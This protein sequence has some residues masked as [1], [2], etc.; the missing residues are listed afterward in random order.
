MEITNR[1]QLILGKFSKNDLDSNFSDSYEKIDKLLASVYDHEYSKKG[2]YSDDLDDSSYGTNSSGLTLIKNIK[3]VEN[4]FDLETIDKIS[5]DA[6]D[7]YG[8]YEI[9]GNEEYLAK[10]TKDIDLLKNLLL[11]KD[12]T[13][14]ESKIRIKKTILEIAKKLK[15]EL[16]NNPDIVPIGTKRNFCSSEFNKSKH[17]DIHKTISKNIKNY[18]KNK[19]K[20]Y[21]ENTYFYPNISK[22]RTVDVILVVDASGSLLS[23]LIYSAIIS[24][25]FY[26][27]P[28]INIKLVLF[29]TRIVDLSDIKEDPL[30]ILLNVSLG[31][32]TDIAL[33][34]SYS[35]KL[36]KN[37]YDTLFIV[38]TDLFSS[39]S[40]MLKEFEEIKESG[41]NLRVLTGID[42]NG[43][44]YYNNSF[45]K[46]LDNLGID[47]S[48]V[49]TKEIVAYIK[50]AMFR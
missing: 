44:T 17:L 45:A 28:N 20:F 30:N 8:M 36:I 50:G 6:V 3:D 1:W 47:V 21:V 16:E 40:P 24:S 5:I 41:V 22:K 42:D 37:P 39:E 31:G 18:D 26:N 32:G 43:K 23:S 13:N 34:L 9:L 15:K 48:S 19:S 29:D 46:K 4:I 35:K 12:L 38:I 7:S 25:I 10:A 2:L 49:T 14:E 27:V 11:Y 33:A